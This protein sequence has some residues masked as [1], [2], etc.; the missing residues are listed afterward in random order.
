[1]F[2]S[3]SGFLGKGK[4]KGKKSDEEVKQRELQDEKMITAA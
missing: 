1:M 2:G 3:F 4:D